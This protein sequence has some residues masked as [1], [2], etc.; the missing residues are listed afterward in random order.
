MDHLIGK[1]KRHRAVGWGSHKEKKS[2]PGG[3][4]QKVWRK[5]KVGGQ[6]IAQEGERIEVTA[7]Y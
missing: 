5:M 4:G 3:V 7:G 6:K 2:L 1:K